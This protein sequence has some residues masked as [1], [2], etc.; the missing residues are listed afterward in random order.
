MPHGAQ[1]SGNITVITLAVITGAGT[2][3]VG[4]DITLACATAGGTWTSSDDTKAT[5]DPL[6]GVVHG[7]GATGGINIYYTMPNGAQNS[8]AVIVTA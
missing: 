4:D 2:V 5:V 3:A 1:V 6:T 7:V 8:H